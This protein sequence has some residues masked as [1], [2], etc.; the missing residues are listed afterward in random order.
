MS[1]A[2]ISSK[3]QI[4]IPS[5]VR[6][7][8]AAKIGDVLQFEVTGESAEIRVFR[9]KITDL[10]GALKNKVSGLGDYSKEKI[11]LAAIRTQEQIQFI[12][13]LEP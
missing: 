1:T 7:A 8:I 13:R 2:K 5:D 9:P 11:M 3:W 12:K 4:N 6:K 10:A